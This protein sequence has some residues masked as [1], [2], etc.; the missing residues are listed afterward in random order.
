MI[1]PRNKGRIHNPCPVKRAGRD[2]LSR[3]TGDGKHPDSNVGVFA[4]RACD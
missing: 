1:L 4:W 3:N 2:I